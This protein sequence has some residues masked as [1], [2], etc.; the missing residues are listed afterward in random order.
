MA[1]SVICWL[2]EAKR[3]L[4]GERAFLAGKRSEERNVDVYVNEYTAICLS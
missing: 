3:T 2:T 4:R 1:I